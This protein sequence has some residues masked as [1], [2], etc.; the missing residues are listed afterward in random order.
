MSS[1]KIWH[2]NPILFRIVRKDW[3]IGAIYG[4]GASFVGL[5]LHGQ[6]IYPLWVFVFPCVEL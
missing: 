2:I 4:L 6:V 1:W 3:N 5:P